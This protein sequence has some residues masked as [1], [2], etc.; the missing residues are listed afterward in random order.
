[1]KMGKKVLQI[2][3]YHNKWGWGAKIINKHK[4]HIGTLTLNPDEL[5]R[6]SKEI[7]FRGTCKEIKDGK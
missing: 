3:I 2:N 5:R 1:M 6:K 4:K 7:N